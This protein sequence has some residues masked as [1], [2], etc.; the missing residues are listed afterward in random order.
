LKHQLPTAVLKK[1]C[2]LTYWQDNPS[3]F[4][5]LAKIAEIVLGISASSAPVKRLFSV[6]GKVFRPEKI[7]RLAD[8]TFEKLMFIRC[9]DKYL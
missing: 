5:S 3:T 7:C 8:S 2:P 1:M 9:I 6:A 4:P